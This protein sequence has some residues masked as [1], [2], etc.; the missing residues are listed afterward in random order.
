MTSFEGGVELSPDNRAEPINDA[1]PPNMASQKYAP[2]DSESRQW[3]TGLCDCLLPTGDGL[4]GDSSCCLTC[5][6][7]VFGFDYCLWKDMDELYKDRQRGIAYDPAK[8]FVPDPGCEAWCGHYPF[9][10]LGFVATWAAT[11]ATFDLFWCCCL[12]DQRSKVRAMYGIPGSCCADFCTACCCRCCMFIQLER[13]LREAAP[14]SRSEPPH[15][16]N[17]MQV[18]LKR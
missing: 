10:A 14:A 6:C 1:C 4:T 16:L 2:V 18:R 15:V 11:F 9:R 7:L 13:Q 3:S 5:C 12:T 17:S 8:A